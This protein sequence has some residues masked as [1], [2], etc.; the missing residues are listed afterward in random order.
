MIRNIQD[1]VQI[2][3]NGGGM[4]LKATDFTVINLV[5]IAAQA[6]GK[7]SRLFITDIDRLSQQDLVQ[8]ASN[9]KGCVV[10]DFSN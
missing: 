1:Y 8:I 9:G 6:S 3:A 10:F 2:A 7:G 5:Q 4:R